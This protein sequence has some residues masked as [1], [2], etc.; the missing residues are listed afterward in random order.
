MK[1]PPIKKIMREDLKDAP[2]WVTGIIDPFNSFA[3]AVYQTL[4]KN[5]DSN[6]LASVIKEITYKT[7]S[8]Y[9]SNQEKTSFTN[10]LKT[11]MQGVK[12]IFAVDKSDY[13]PA[14]GPVYAPA[15]EVNG[16]IEI[17]TITGLEAGKTYLI[18]IELI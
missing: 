12:V 10:P 2:G 1:L 4:N 14:P 11:R 18:R 7:A 3:E 5:V 8:T 16:N 17:S 6:N 13:K 15:V 9:P